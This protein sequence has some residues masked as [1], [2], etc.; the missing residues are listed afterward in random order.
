MSGLEAAA[1]RTAANVVARLAGKV[2]R[3]RRNRRIRDDS[4]TAVA[5]QVS[6]DLLTALNE[7][8]IKAMQKY[9]NSPDFEEIALQLALSQLL[10]DREAE[11]LQPTLREEIRLGL[12]HAVGLPSTLLTTGADVLFDALQVAVLEA[13]KGLPPGNVDPVVAS[14]VAHLAAAAVSNT[15][16][17]ERVESLVEFHEF[18]SQLRSQ[19]ARLHAEMRLPHLGASRSVPYEQLY[20]E[21]TVDGIAN[22]LQPGNR[23]VILG[24]PGAGKSTLAAKLAWEVASTP[25]G[26]VPF[27]MVLRNFASSFRAGG[28]RLIDYLEVLCGDPYNLTPPEDAVEYLLLNGRAI[29]LLDGIDELVDAEVRQRFARLV[30]SFAHLYPSVP[31][32]LTAR[33]VGYETAALD[34]NLFTTVT[35]EDF[36]ESAVARYVWRWFA[37]DASTP[38]YERSKMAEAFLQESST[39]G[40]LRRNP[41]LLA[42]LCAMFSNEHYL[43]KNLA[44]VYEKCALLLFEQWDTMRGLPSPLRFESRLRGAVGHL[45]WNQFNAENSGAAWPRSRIVRV[46]TAYLHGRGFGEDEA[47]DTAN[48]FV[49]FCTGRSWVL[50]DTGMDPREPQYGFTHRTFLEF[51]SADYLVRTSSAAKPLWQKLRSM[52]SGSSLVPQIALQLYDQKHDDGASKLLRLAAQDRDAG[53]VTFAAESLQYTQPSPELQRLVAAEAVSNASAFGVESYFNYWHSKKIQE[54]YRRTLAPLECLVQRSAHASRNIIVRA[55]DDEL[56]RLTSDE[57]KHITANWL[58]HWLGISVDAGPEPWASIFSGAASLTALVENFGPRVLYLRTWGMSNSLAAQALTQ[59]EVDLDPHSLLTARLPWIPSSPWTSDLQDAFE[60]KML[61]TKN[62]PVHVLLALPYLEARDELGLDL[63]EGNRSIRR[64]ARA[65]PDGTHLPLRRLELPAEVQK[66]L[67]K[68]MIR[69]VSVVGPLESSH[70]NN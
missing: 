29:V 69:K 24:D 22:I 53:G 47:E 21:P 10:H 12:R 7:S 58:R 27:L 30:E 38:E 46:L 44:Q 33:K 28:S 31:M 39:I 65:R 61:I 50:V 3:A 70:Q 8:Q 62:T 25:E 35:I 40:E 15:R 34:A 42:L 18:S 9:V 64:L 14:S 63:S 5:T 13:L 17:L 19:V 54:H 2:G 48:R 41:L 16:L 11:K 56:L 43:P 26:R 4:R 66:F 59:D 1:G 37:L 6:D 52:L 20:V 45:A 60:R 55:V 67:R 36:D 49:E 23:S 32:I 68:W 57:S 51:F